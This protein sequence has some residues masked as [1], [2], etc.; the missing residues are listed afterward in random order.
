[1]FCW[2]DLQFESRWNRLG[3]LPWCRGWWHPMGCLLMSDFSRTVHHVFRHRWNG[4]D[5]DMISPISKSTVKGEFGARSLKPQTNCAQIVIRSYNGV[6]LTAM[7]IPLSQD[8]FYIQMQRAAFLHDSLHPKPD[9]CRHFGCSS[10]PPRETIHGKVKWDHPR[11]RQG[12]IE[13]PSLHHWNRRC[14]L[15]VSYIYICK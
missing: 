15:Y 7:S 2:H 13:P 5:S 8:L 9:F 4:Q 10:V 11:N 1:M 6:R 14:W 12:F 3:L